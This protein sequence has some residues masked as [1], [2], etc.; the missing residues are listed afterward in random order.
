[1]TSIKS[2]LGNRDV[3]PQESDYLHC[4]F[5]APVHHTPPESGIHEVKRGEGMDEWLLP[6][7]AHI[8][9][10]LPQNHRKFPIN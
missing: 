7:S 8:L 9:S 2:T 10:S 6:T 3:N 4:Q 5:P 1:M